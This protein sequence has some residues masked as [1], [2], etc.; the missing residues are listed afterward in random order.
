MDQREEHLYKLILTKGKVTLNLIGRNL[1]FLYQKTINRHN[2]TLANKYES[3]L[4]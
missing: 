3:L 2:K 4:D 1:L